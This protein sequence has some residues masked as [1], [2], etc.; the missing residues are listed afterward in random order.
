M[1]MPTRGADATRGQ[2]LRPTQRRG[3]VSLTKTTNKSIADVGLVAVVLGLVAVG[4]ML[5]TAILAHFKH[6]IDA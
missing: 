6:A 3:N 5:D 4:R 1:S 2:D